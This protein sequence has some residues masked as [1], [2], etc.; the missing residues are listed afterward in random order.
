MGYAG[1][2]YIGLCAYTTWFI[3]VEPVAIWCYTF[4]HDLAFRQDK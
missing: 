3:A 4:G 2:I 1:K